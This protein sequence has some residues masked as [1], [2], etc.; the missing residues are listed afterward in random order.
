M[1]RHSRQGQPPS[2]QRQSRKRHR[3][4]CSVAMTLSVVT[5][6]ACSS[7]ADTVAARHDAVQHSLDALVSED[8]L[9][10][11][12]ASIQD[13]NGNSHNYTAGVGDLTTGSEVPPNG[14]IRIGSNTKTFTAVVVLQ[15]VAEGKIELDTPIETYLP[16]LV[17]GDGIDGH[18]ITIR[19]LLQHTSG[20]PNYSNYLEDEVRY[21]DPRELLDIAL[22]HPAD[23]APGTS[24]KYS[25]TNYVLAGLLVQKVTGRPVAEEMNRRI[26]API[27]LRDTYFPS[28]GDM[29]IRGP[30]P[31][32]Y[33]R[34]AP[35]SPLSDVTEMDPSWGW[36]AG[37]LISTTSDLN[38]FLHALLDGRLLP[39][40]Q[41]DQM[42]TTVPAEETFGP[43][44]RYGLGLVS[45]PLPCG[46]LS[47]S[48]GGSFPGY[49]TR[50][51]ATDDGRE[52]NIAVSMQV[53]DDATRRKLEHAV[54]ITLCR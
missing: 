25:N 19:Q 43:D 21:Y 28:P 32:G 24:W 11:A 53:V 26:F 27:G 23:F 40:A 13:R 51:G 8:G 22:E 33:H 7:S 46:G 14:Q 38:Q 2:P 31:K 6:G 9:P 36:A 42:R 48:H 16:G 15:L 12:L 52:A 45:R 3:A 54:D 50:G 5:L 1:R 29:T 18:N 44:A 34:T 47:W 41:L 39:A 49:E 4:L 35:D 20:L 10:A 30:H 17:R 37:Q